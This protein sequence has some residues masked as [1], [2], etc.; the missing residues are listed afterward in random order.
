[1]FAECVTQDAPYYTTEEANH[2]YAMQRLTS[3]NQ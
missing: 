2:F 3:F 1:M